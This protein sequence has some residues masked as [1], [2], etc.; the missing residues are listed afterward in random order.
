MVQRR[1]LALGWVLAV[2]GNSILNVSLKG[3][4]E[5]VRPLHEHGLAHGPGLQLP[6]RPQLRCSVVA[7]GMLA[8]VAMRAACRRCGIC[9]RCF[10]PPRSPSRPDAAASSCRCIS[11]ATC[12]PAFASG[13][14]WLVVCISGLETVR[15]RQRTG[16]EPE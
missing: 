6:Q 10:W 5:R 7:Y 2:A 3:I 13:L 11:P 9:R 14:A 8:Y 4:F 16:L 12:W 1:A 15:Y